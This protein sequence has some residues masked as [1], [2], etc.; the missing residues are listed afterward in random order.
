[1]SK[2]EGKRTLG[3]PKRKWKDNIAMELGGIGWDGN[4]PSDFI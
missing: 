2:P 4:E 1:V 3:R